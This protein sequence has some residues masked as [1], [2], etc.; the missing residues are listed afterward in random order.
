M[1]DIA[2]NARASKVTLYKYFVDKDTLYFQVSKQIFA[3]Y[4]MQLEYVLASDKD[5][6]SKFYDY[7]GIISEFIDSGQFELC[8]ELARYNSE[9]ETEYA[10]YRQT[11]RRSMLAL[12]DEGIANGLVRRD[13]DRDMY[14]YYIDM[15]ILYYQQNSEYRSKM[16]NDGDFQRRFVSFHIG[17]IFTDDARTRLSL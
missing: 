10:L 2:E 3:R 11:Y 1:D 8:R 13:L 9:I 15:G 16:L 17:N 14:F 7:L 5:L 6:I 4:T 12:I